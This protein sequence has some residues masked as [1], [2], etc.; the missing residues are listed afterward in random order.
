MEGGSIFFNSDEFP[1]KN[2]AIHDFFTKA[3]KCNILTN[4]SA[5]GT[6]LA[7]T[8]SST[9]LLHISTTKGTISICKKL[10]LKIAYIGYGEIMI[11]GNQKRKVTEAEFA[12]EL[13]ITKQIYKNSLTVMFD[14]ICP[15]VLTS[16][17]NNPASPKPDVAPA[18]RHLK[19][20]GDQ[21]VQ[22]PIIR[23][24]FAQHI[25][26]IMMELGDGTAVSDVFPGWGPGQTYE[27]HDY[28]NVGDIKSVALINY[29]IQLNKLKKLGMNHG[30]AHLGN[31][32]LCK[33]DDSIHANKGYYYRGY[34]VLLLDFGKTTPISPADI[35]DLNYRWYTTIDYWSY[36]ALNGVYDKLRTGTL[37]MSQLNSAIHADTN[38]TSFNE[39]MKII[40]DQHYLAWLLTISSDPDNLV[41]MKKIIKTNR[42]KYPKLEKRRFLGNY[43]NGVND[44]E[45]KQWLFTTANVPLRTNTFNI[46][47]T[48]MSVNASSNCC[49]NTNGKFYN[50][51]SKGTVYKHPFA[52]KHQELVRH[53]RGKT[54]AR[55]AAGIYLWIIGNGPD[56]VTDVYYILVSNPGEIA[57]KHAHL[58]HYA[59]IQN[60]YMAGEL[61]KVNTTATT[62]TIN[63]NLASGTF[64]FTPLRTEFNHLASPDDVTRMNSTLDVYGRQSSIFLKF[65]LSDKDYTCTVTYDP[66]TIAPARNTLTPTYIIGSNATMCASVRSSRDNYGIPMNSY[67]D[68]A[69]CKAVVP[70]PAVKEFTGGG[71]LEDIDI[72]KDSM[73][74]T[75]SEDYE[76]FNGVPSEIINYVVKEDLDPL[77]EGD[78]QENEDSF[79]S[80]LLKL[81]YIIKNDINYINIIDDKT[82]SSLVSVASE[83]R[84]KQMIETNNE[85]P[86]LIAGKTRKFV[87][88]KSKR[89]IV[90]RKSKRKFR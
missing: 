89:K 72:A 31:A 54:L 3:T 66:T 48:T 69:L 15:A 60:Y 21:G 47:T 46:V 37:H 43:P 34:K 70:N 24:I 10:I 27:L 77:P 18:I 38:M 45:S 68:S 16:F 67:T 8:S 30:D 90:R 57:T 41:K 51:Y 35:L 40:R 76:L 86:Q 56:G 53:G 14:P 85:Y 2:T 1:N 55:E 49:P 29:A 44:Q 22:G 87:R 58:M 64:M 26:V 17:L 88:R 11:G 84:E 7:I 50:Y 81:I 5:Y 79:M 4:D 20:L 78:E 13:E 19:D 73:F 82:E 61:I 9:G 80:N 32:L 39:Y 33:V 12:R 83:L 42:T 36:K 52:L 74:F 28:S 71:Q 25:G 59:N 62:S 6:I 63:Y 65:I 23:S 75:F